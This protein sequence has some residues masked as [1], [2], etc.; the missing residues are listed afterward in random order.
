VL[1]KQKLNRR[2]ERRRERKGESMK[3]IGPGLID[4]GRQGKMEIIRGEVFDAIGNELFRYKKVTAT[5]RAS[6]RYRSS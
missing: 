3:Q 5:E 6:A 1:G 2:G 4:R